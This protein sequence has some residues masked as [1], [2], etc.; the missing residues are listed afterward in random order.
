[1]RAEIVFHPKLYRK[2]GGL[3][4]FLGDRL[5]EE[6]VRPAYQAYR[7]P[8]SQVYEL[9]TEDG[10]TIVFQEWEPFLRRFL[11][12]ERFPI[13]IPA[14]H[15]DA[16]LI[17]LAQVRLRSVK[18]VPPLNLVGALIPLGQSSTPWTSISGRRSRRP[19]K[20][21]RSAS[22][23]LPGLL[24]LVFLYILLIGLV[25]IF[26]DQILRDLSRSDS[27]ISPA[28]I[29]AAILLPLF[30]LA[31]IAVNLL[32]LLRDRTRRKPGAQFKSRLLLFFL[33]ASS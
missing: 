3:L 21:F 28:V 1:M 14:D 25:L 23:T 18:L 29:L 30:L 32:R 27:P 11:T 15:R 12:L 20:S 24:S 16:R 4:R 10:S 7:D 5:V 6:E 19:M 22:P 2:G 31:M 9:V 33:F 8:F 13:T 17:L 26:S